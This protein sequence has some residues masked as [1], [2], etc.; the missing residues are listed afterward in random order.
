MN[1]NFDKLK[2]YAISDSGLVFHAETGAIFTTNQTGLAILN[3][4]RQ[5][6]TATTIKE[7]ILVEYEGCLPLEVDQD[8]DDYIEQLILLGMVERTH[9]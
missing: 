9:G 5:G 2:D 3:N 7:N 8:V 1:L 6:T 4:L